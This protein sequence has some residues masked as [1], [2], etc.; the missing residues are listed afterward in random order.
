LNKNYLPISVYAFYINGADVL[1]LSTLPSMLSIL[2]RAKS[3]RRQ[4]R[5]DKTF[6]FSTPG[7]IP[8]WVLCFSAIFV[9]R[10]S[11]FALHLPLVP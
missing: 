7:T 3:Q 9:F 11:L 1:L 8:A 2:R 6:L 4:M 5:P 10:F